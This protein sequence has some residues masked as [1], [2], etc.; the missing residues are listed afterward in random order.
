MQTE[1]HL[2]RATLRRRQSVQ[3]AQHRTAQLL[4]SREWEFHLRLDTRGPRYLKSG[5][6]RH[7]IFEQGRLAHPWFPADHQDTALAGASSQEQPIEFLTF[8]PSAQQ[9][10]EG[11]GSGHMRPFH[12]KPVI[13]TTNLGDVP[14][15][16]TLSFLSR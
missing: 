15:E 6:A 13:E 12:W 3:P 7:R 1:C 5:G 10:S 4:K 16:A 8:L 9:V 14:R 2:K 11:P